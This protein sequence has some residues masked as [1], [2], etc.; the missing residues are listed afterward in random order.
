MNNV[1]IFS[2]DNKIIAVVKLYL[3]YNLHGVLYHDW[4]RAF[5]KLEVFAPKMW[6]FH[7]NGVLNYLLVSQSCSGWIQEL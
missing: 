4:Q 7:R 2:F 3:L 5:C 1:L 6:N